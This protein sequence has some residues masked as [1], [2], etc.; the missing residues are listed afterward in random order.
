MILVTGACGYIGSHFLRYYLERSPHTDLVA[1]DNL[2]VGH[3]EVLKFLDGGRL[4]FYPID[5]GNP[6]VVGILKRH[7]VDAVVH[8]A[9]NA[10]VGESQVLPFKYFRNNVSETLGL[11]ESMDKCGI[12]KLVFSST[13]ATYGNPRYS[14]INEEHPQKPINT[15]G[16]TKVMVEEA[17]RSQALCRGLRYVCLRYFNAAGA[18]PSGE[19]GESHAPETHLLPL[20]IAAAMGKGPKL[21]VYGQDYPTADGTCVRDYIHVN[22]LADAHCRAL[23]LLSA[24]YQGNLEEANG[25]GMALNLGTAQGASVKEVIAQVE[26]VVGSPVPH[27]F[28]ERRPGDPAYLVADYSKAKSILGWQPAY[29]LRAIVETASNWEAKRTY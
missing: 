4:H 3:R 28:A 23:D 2:S 13:C 27:E 16:T 29:D 11:L 26:A 6:E 12:K 24:E 7:E 19:I 17:L 15:Y 9:A 1:I 14:P 21:K 20:A 5:I 22:D 8:F 25:L 18:H 10:Y